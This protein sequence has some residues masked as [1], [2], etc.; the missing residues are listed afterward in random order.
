MC[1]Q[2]SIVCM[3]FSAEPRCR[4]DCSAIGK[5]E[6]TETISSIASTSLGIWS[7][8][9]TRGQRIFVVACRDV[10]P[11]AVLL[12][13]SDCKW[14]PERAG[15]C[16]SGGGECSGGGVRGASPGASWARWQP[17]WD[18]RGGQPCGP[19]CRA[20]PRH[21]GGTRCCVSLPAHMARA[22]CPSQACTDGSMQVRRQTV[23]RASALAAP[24]NC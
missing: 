15:L 4:A 7:W 17:C 16:G 9:V 20:A 18:Q 21:P 23:K 6:W 11:D 13:D 8:Q 1:N 24:Q 10:P 12:A 2:A 19:G 5:A 22:E 3:D 14:R